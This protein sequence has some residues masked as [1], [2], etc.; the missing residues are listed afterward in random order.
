MISVD[1]N[2][3]IRLLTRDDETQYKKAYAAFQKNE[4]FIS[5]TVLLETEWVLRYAYS[6][7][8]QQVFDA[9][10]K[11]LGLPNISVTHP[12][13]LHTALQNHSK[14]M[15]FA[16]ALHLA[17]SQHCDKMLSFDTAFINQAKDQHIC[18][19]SLP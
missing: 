12:T 14:G 3:I 16:D 19:V 15:D 13:A 5:D 8:R 4:L 10:S 9:L 6:F 7:P 2:I 11:L 17:L 1:T 18:P